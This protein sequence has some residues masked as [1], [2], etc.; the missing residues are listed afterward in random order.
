MHAWKISVQ[1]YLVYMYKF[2]K[3]RA[4]NWGV[5]N[6]F[7]NCVQNKNSLKTL[8]SR[9]YKNIIMQWP[10]YHKYKNNWINWRM[11]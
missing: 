11:K 10:F 9:V 4:T 3:G 6:S 7:E 5:D 1:K 8:L 2:Q